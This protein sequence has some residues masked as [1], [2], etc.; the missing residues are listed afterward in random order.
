ML[1]NEV[2]VWHVFL[3]SPNFEIE[4]QLRILS[5]EELERASQFHFERDKKRFIATRGI[6][7]KILSYYLGI[8][9]QMI[10]FEYT[11]YGKPVLA[12]KS[13][14]SSKRTNHEIHKLLENRISQG[15]S[16]RSRIELEIIQ[17]KK[18]L[19]EKE[20]PIDSHQA[21]KQRALISKATK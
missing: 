9:P 1:S 16:T 4:N 20:N 7:R 11:F 2:H 13:Q 8:S 15:C 19:S 5:V 3:D 12:S 18:R 6:L 10:R 14:L 21:K 17:Y